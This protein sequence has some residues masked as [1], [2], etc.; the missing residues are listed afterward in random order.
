MPA[1]PVNMDDFLSKVSN[2]YE[3]VIVAAKRARQIH[4]DVKIA[5]NKHIETLQQLQPTQI[6]TEDDTEPVP[7]PDQ[8]RISLQFES[9]P[10]P[11]EIAVNELLDGKLKWRYAEEEHAAG[12]AEEESE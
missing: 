9:L 7:N 10:K 8:S 1:T 11:T 5:L 4:S 12:K 6:D 3:A 2:V